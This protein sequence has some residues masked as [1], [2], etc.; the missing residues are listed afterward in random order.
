MLSMAGSPPRLCWGGSG[1]FCRGGLFGGPPPPPTSFFSP[2]SRSKNSPRRRSP[3]L[4]GFVPA[5]TNGAGSSWQ[6]EQSRQ[7]KGCTRGPRE[8]SFRSASPR[9]TRGLVERARGQGTGGNSSPRGKH[10]QTLP[11]KVPRATGLAPADML[12]VRQHS[13]SSRAAEASLPCGWFKTQT[14]VFKCSPPDFRTPWKCCLANF[15]VVHSRKHERTPSPRPRVSNEWPY[16]CGQTTRV[17]IPSAS[18]LARG[19]SENLQA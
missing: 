13:L 15:A 14:R 6:Y 11:A 12:L 9:L 10:A 5:P 7:S 8:R 18:P 16:R 3:A 17:Q 4:R 19:R 1:A 2:S